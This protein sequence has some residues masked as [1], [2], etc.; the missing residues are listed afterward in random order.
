MDQRILI[1]LK[2]VLIIQVT[3]SGA[4]AQEEISKH[5]LIYKFRE[6]KRWEGVKF[7]RKKQRSST[8]QLASLVFYE[9]GWRAKSNNVESDTVA[10]F[11]TTPDV[12]HTR[13]HVY[14]L[15]R[16]YFM[17]TPSIT[18][19]KEGN[20][21][22]KWPTRILDAIKLEQNMLKGKVQARLK[23]EPIYFPLYFQIPDSTV[24]NLLAEITFVTDKDMT[25]NV[26]LYFS[27]SEDPISLGKNIEMTAEKEKS[28]YWKVNPELFKKGETIKIMVTD[29]ESEIGG[30][31]FY[32]YWN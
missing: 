12:K 10:I 3:I 1:L 28:V 30:D 11:Y 8:L 29:K 23:N 19:Q 21:A 22:F 6:Q 16:S 9:E 15:E 18:F 24:R 7:K 32:I 27:G 25:I 17:D 14:N 13:I 31:D 2:A 4:E 26:D 5:E 20:Y